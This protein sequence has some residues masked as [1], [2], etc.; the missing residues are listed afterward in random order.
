MYFS[1]QINVV[2]ISEWQFKNT[3]YVWYGI[4]FLPV[5]LKFV[6]HGSLCTNTS[7]CISNTQC[8]VSILAVIYAQRNHHIISLFF[9]CCYIHIVYKQRK[10]SVCSFCVWGLFYIS[11]SIR[12]LYFDAMLIFPELCSSWTFCK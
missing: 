12:F 5:H 10:W 8:N 7:L 11:I 1:V 2:Q 6:H 9:N 3:F 4:C